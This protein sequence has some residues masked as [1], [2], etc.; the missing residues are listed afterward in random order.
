LS[1]PDERPNDTSRVAFVDVLYLAFAGT[2]LT[3]EPGEVLTFGKEADL[4]I[5]AGDE[6]LHRQ[7]GRIA[8][9]GSA[10]WLTNCGD[11]IVISVEDA[12]GPSFKQLAPGTRD[13]LSYGEFF[14]RF[15]TRVA[16]YE[17]EG[18]LA[19]RNQ[20]HEPTSAP[21]DDTRT[22]A[23]G[24]VALAPDERRL[25]AALAESRLE[26]GRNAQVA[27][28]ANDV[29]QE[30]LGIRATTYNRRLDHLCARFADAGV[31]GLVASDGRPARD[32]RH[33]LVEH[34]LRYGLIGRADLDLLT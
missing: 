30:R 28:P 7:L 19:E 14:V 5:D 25:L 24:E 3:L 18:S 10:W 20:P 8:Y 34:A 17:L 6:Y 26:A 13:V 21:D 11:R 9:D 1:P 16:R 4:V 31:E 32:R 2:E 22:G 15:R 29:V 12:N 27:L 33:V 23:W